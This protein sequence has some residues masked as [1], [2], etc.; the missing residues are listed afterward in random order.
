[1]CSVKDLAQRYNISYV[2]A[3]QL[4]KEFKSDPDCLVR[5]RC[6]EQIREEKVKAISDEVD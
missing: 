5:L 3:H 1:M 2:L 4:T 6:K